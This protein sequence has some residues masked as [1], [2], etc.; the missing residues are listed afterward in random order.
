MT[1]KEILF[2]IAKCLTINHNSENKSRVT[3]L[4]SSGSVDWD[5]VVQ[6]STSQYVFP[7]LYIN[8]KRANLLSYLSE[9]LVNYMD[10][11]TSLN[12]ERNLEI[13]QQA[14]ELNSE[15]KKNGID[16]IFLKGTGFLLQNFYH[17][18][19][20]R[21]VGDIDFLVS[22]Q[23]YH[24]TISA[25]NEIGYDFVAKTE[26][27]FPAYKHHP[28]LQLESRIAAVEIHHEMTID[29]YAK[30]FNYEFIE[31]HCQITNN[32]KVLSY[33]D[34]LILTGIAKQIN[35]NGYELNTMSLRNGYDI[36]LLSNKVDT[37]K[38][39]QPFN[40]LFNPLN[41][42][43]A[44]CSLI[45]DTNGIRFEKNNNSKDAIQL[46]L[47]IYEDPTFGKKHLNNKKSRIFWRKRMRF[48][49]KSFVKKDYAFWIFKRMT[50]PQWY[51]EKMIQLGFKSKN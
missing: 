22:K 34:Q 8:L 7:A 23:D 27:H 45:F 48:I 3:D 49:Q 14:K 20:E 44:L 40:L 2:F 1:N 47:K 5:K 51:K 42:F 36:M 4:I 41:N 38:A 32:Y 39:I 13:I 11:I 31:E 16:P 28:R 50:D 29:E 18:P 17:D 6:I 12:R 26:Y 46:F 15:L 19:G 30:E 35:D 24:R 33:E 21:M 10:H 9:E 43:L 37:L 25:L